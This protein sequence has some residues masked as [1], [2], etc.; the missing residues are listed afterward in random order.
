V[1]DPRAMTDVYQAAVVRTWDPD[2]AGVDLD[3]AL[4]AQERGE[5]AVVLTAWN[6]GDARWSK[7]QNDRANDRM[8][9]E[10]MATGLPVW[11]ADGSNPE[12]TFREPGFCVWGMSVAGGIALARRF[13]QFAVY[14]YLPSG[15]REIVWTDD[16]SLTPQIP[17][18]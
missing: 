2:R 14:V 10:L 13:D 8:R 18:R 11:A 15:A 12:G 3:P 7:A 5:Q 6:P 1:N 9:T 4:V 17:E 16:E